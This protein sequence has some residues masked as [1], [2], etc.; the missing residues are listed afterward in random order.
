MKYKLAIFD[1][2][3]TL[4]NSLP[5]FITVVNQ[6]ADSHKFRR[7]E[8]H[9]QKT[10]RGYDARKVLQH[11]EI[12]MWKV[13]MIARDLR[14][15][16]TQDIDNIILFDGV[17]RMLQSLSSNGITLAIVSS[18]STANIRRV[19][20]PENSA[21]IRH[22]ECGASLFGKRKKFRNVLREF[23]ISPAEAI[24][25]GDELRDLQAA[26]AEKIPFGAVP[27]GYTTVESLVASSPEE[28][29]AT[30]EEI[31]AKLA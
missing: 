25:I 22:F 27:W 14:Q 10:L 26:R 8:V 28:L 7:I 31:A 2:D 6:I 1:F 23:N 13:P 16:M 15:R 21:L 17:D 3:G 20:G 4:A 19:L 18:N 24:C 5:W 30:M 9:E 29:F 12:P 11:L